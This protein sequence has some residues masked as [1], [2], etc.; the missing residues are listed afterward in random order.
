MWVTSAS[1][2]RSHLAYWIIRLWNSEQRVQVW[3]RIEQ[4]LVEG[5]EP[6]F[7]LVAAFLPVVI[8]LKVEVLLQ[9]FDQRQ[10]HP[11]FCVGDA[12]GFQQLESAARSGLQ[13]MKQAR[14]PDSRLTDHSDHLA[15]PQEDA[16][17][18]ALHL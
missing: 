10:I 9:Q 3:D 5:R 11:S 18:R 2:L 7:D 8:G 15:M 13:L 1:E 6:A 17:E 14:L 12:R 4:R 16:I